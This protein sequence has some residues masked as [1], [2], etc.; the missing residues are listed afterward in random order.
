M[1]LGA[2]FVWNLRRGLESIARKGIEFK[3]LPVLTGA[4][5][6]VLMPNKEPFASLKS[7]RDEKCNYILQFTSIQKLQQATY[8]LLLTV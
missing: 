2:T 4:N 5:M 1:K 6:A 3:D 8:H 7:I